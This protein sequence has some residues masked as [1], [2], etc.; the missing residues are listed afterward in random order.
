MGSTLKTHFVEPNSYD[1]EGHDHHVVTLCGYAIP[2]QEFVFGS[3]SA[4][5]ADVT[6]KLCRGIL[7]RR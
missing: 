2:A 3:R 5:E 4:R 6:C 7:E 1:G